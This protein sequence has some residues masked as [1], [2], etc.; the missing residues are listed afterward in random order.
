MLGARGRRK[1][2][3]A[4][5]AAW[6]LLRSEDVKAQAAALEVVESSLHGT[7]ASLIMPLLDSSPLEKQ[8]RTSARR[9]SVRAYGRRRKG[10][11]E[12]RTIGTYECASTAE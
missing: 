6:K 3:G 5:L 1:A 11:E 7:L 4:V 8:E 9:T 12:R 10:A 2:L